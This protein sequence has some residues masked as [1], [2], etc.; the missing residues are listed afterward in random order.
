MRYRR[1]GKLDWEVSVLGFG[2]MRLPLVGRAL[3]DGYRGKV[4]LAIRRKY[5]SILKFMD[6][7]TMLFSPENAIGAFAAMAD[8]HDFLEKEQPEN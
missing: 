7:D 2:A 5:E 6:R 1:F 8:R 3:E 4:K